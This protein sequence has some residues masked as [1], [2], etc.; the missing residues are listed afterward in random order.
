MGWCLALQCEHGNMKDAPVNGDLGKHLVISARCRS[1]PNPIFTRLHGPYILK[2]EPKTL[3]RKGWYQL[4]SPCLVRC[5]QKSASWPKPGCR[6][7]QGAIGLTDSYSLAM[8]QRTGGCSLRL[9]LMAFFD[10]EPWAL[11]TWCFGSMA[12]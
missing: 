2:T 7:L 4:S 9:A 1:K 3:N 11:V 10:H 12:S 5:S 8:P 6:Q